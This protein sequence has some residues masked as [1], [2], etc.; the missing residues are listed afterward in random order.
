MVPLS[1]I[2]REVVFVAAACAMLMIGCERRTPEDGG[3]LTV[4]VS[5]EP[6]RWLVDQ[7]GGE[8]VEVVCL[9]R[10]GDD[11]H[12]YQPSDIQVSQVARASAFFRIGVPFENGPWFKALE[13]TAKI[14]AVDLRRHVPLIEMQGH[15]HHGHDDHHHDHDHDHDHGHDHTAETSLEEE[16]FDPHIWLT[17]RLLKIQ[18]RTVADT[19]AGLDPAH[20]DTYEANL[21][22]FERRMDVLH[23]D[24]LDTL[25]PIQGKAFYVFHPAWGYLAQ[26]YALEQ[27][28]IETEGKE[29]SD[30]E[31]TEIQNDARARGIK[32][33]FVQPQISGRS[34]QA[35]ANAIGGRVEQ[36]DPYV[37][38]V[39]SNL[40]HV[41]ERLAA[42]FQ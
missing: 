4:A 2:P 31:L 10:P 36:L 29:P 9:V 37:A 1:P 38:D 8:H 39:E 24:L 28:A 26:E 33:V 23:R 6:Q 13:R 15:H 3:R 32:V 18:A 41:A 40:R 30:R 12:S 34:A 20:R 7:I 21:L 35:V 22:A 11:A 42:S 16:G 25:A 5:I 19:L 14:R 17:P 27:K